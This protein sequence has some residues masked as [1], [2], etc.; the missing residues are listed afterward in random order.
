MKISVI[1]AGA[2]GGATVEGLI[3]GTFVNNNDIIVADPC[4]ATLKR[5]ADKGVATTDDNAKAASAADIVMVVVKPWLVETVLKGIRQSLDASRQTLIV[6]AAGVSSTNIREW[7]G[8]IPLF[9]AIPNIAIAELAS[10]TFVV[11]AAP[12]HTGHAD[13]VKA[14]FDSMGDTIFTDEAHLGSGTALAS[15]GIAYALRYIRAASEGG[16]QLGFKADDATRIVAQTVKGAVSLL[17]SSGKHPEQLIDQVT[18]PGGVTIKGLN[19]MEEAGFS[20]AVIK[21]LV[22]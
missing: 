15:C 2:M 16:V 19:A 9:L 7:V 3:K 11:E 20:N 12:Q 18:T 17:E 6:I 8:D 5:F 22:K 10:M 14:L 13:V 1:G 21:G 4:K